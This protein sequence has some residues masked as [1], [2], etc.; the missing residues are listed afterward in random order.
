M[1]LILITLV[2]GGCAAAAD[3]DVR[4]ENDEIVED[5]ALRGAGVTIAQNTMVTIDR[6]R[7]TTAR[8]VAYGDSIFAG[9]QGAIASV[10]RRAAPYVAAEYAAKD[11]DVNVEV[12]RRARSGAVAARVAQVIEENH[13]FMTP[14]TRAV[15]VE[16]C[17]NDYLKARR[18]FAQASGTCDVSVIHDALTACVAGTKTALAT[19]NRYA[20]SGA[21]KVLMNLYYPGFGADDR[22]SLCTDPTTGKPLN[23]QNVLLPVMARSN[24]RACTLARSEGFACADAFAAVM[25]GDDESADVAFDPNE[26]EDAYVARLIERRAVLHDP[27]AKPIGNGTFADYMLDDDIHPTY[28]L[29]TIPIRGAWRSVPDF[30]D[31]QI[32]GGKNPKW[33]ASGHERLGYVLANQLLP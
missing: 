24:W 5:G 1:R 32:Q 22:P 19:I 30:T 12:V 29:G 25:A 10:A 26:P 15:L 11:W 8:V 6:G 7:S 16:L 28:E 21:R 27:N 4:G 13:E 31:A 14:S 23:V 9:Y 17:G 3:V 18:A 20:P 33:N 2:L